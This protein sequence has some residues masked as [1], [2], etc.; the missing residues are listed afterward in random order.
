MGTWLKILDRVPVRLG[1]LPSVYYP[2][3]RLNYFHICAEEGRIVIR[4]VEI[5]KTPARELGL[6]QRLVTLGR[7]LPT[8]PEIPATTTIETPSIDTLARYIDPDE[9]PLPEYTS[10]LAI[11]WQGL[12]AV[13][14]AVMVVSN[15]LR[16]TPAYSPGCWP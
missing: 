4:Y 9:P 2:T 13:V 8:P 16:Q 6:L 1:Y 11:Q 12:I 3:F 15:I 5:P 7:T 10:T 14:L